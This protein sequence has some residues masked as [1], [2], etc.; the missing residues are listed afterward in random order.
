MVYYLLEKPLVFQLVPTVLRYMWVIFFQVFRSMEKLN[1]RAQTGSD[2][3][4][5]LLQLRRG[6]RWGVGVAAGLCSPGLAAARRQDKKKTVFR[7]RWFHSE[8]LGV[9][10]FFE[11][12]MD[13][14]QCQKSQTCVCV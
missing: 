14:L 4:W 2:L 10:P 3:C 11:M 5:W 12:R 7:T 6:D 13:L 9:F 1:P 8:H